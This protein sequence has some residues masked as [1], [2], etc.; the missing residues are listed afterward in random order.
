[1]AN[2]EQK[3]MY[4]VWIPGKG[5]LRGSNNKDVIADYNKDVA[6]Q[7]AKRIGERARVF[8]VDTSLIDLEEQLLKAEQKPKWFLFRRQKG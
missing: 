4:G 2:E 3:I 5:W 1:M 8:F 6:E 7:I